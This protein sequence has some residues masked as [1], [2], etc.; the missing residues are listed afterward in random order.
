MPSDHR[1]PQLTLDSSQKVGVLLTL[2]AK[3]REEI[4]T[5]QGHLFTASFW[6][7]GGILALGAFGLEA[8]QA[9][10]IV[11]LAVG[12]VVV[13]A[14]SYTL[15][16]HVARFAIEACGRD[17][18]RLQEALYLTQK[19]AYLSNETIY[20]PTK[21]WLPQRYVWYLRSLTWALSLGTVLGLAGR[22]P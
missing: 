22:L 18:L 10:P 17:L 20:V 19:D 13:L 2:L 16:T 15:L 5:W 21:V 7:T 1:S 14:L 8:T 12:G 6:F 3:N 4:A 11:R 9:L